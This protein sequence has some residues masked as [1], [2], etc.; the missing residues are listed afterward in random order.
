MAQRWEF[1]DDRQEFSHWRKATPP[2]SSVEYRWRP[3]GLF[4]RLS[5]RKGMVTYCIEQV[6]S[7]AELDTIRL[8]WRWL[9]A[10]KL[11]MMRARL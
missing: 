2:C 5:R 3:Q 9:M 1:A 4:I 10:Q 8:G 7:Q 6:V 11:R